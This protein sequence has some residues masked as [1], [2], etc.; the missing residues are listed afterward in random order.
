MEKECTR[1]V[2][3][4]FKSFYQILSSLFRHL[5]NDSTPTFSFSGKILT[6]KKDITQRQVE[7][8]SNVLNMDSNVDEDHIN[9][10]LR[11]SIL[12]GLS[13]TQSI[14]EIKLTI[15]Q[16]KNGKYSVND[17]VQAE[18]YNFGR[19]SRLLYFVISFS[20]I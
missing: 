12:E 18:I 4:Y 3:C 6:D 19:N 7:N 15:K 5:S 1:I 14:A 11:M 8:F 13:A 9:N 17:G 10:L 20:L 2:G 16:L